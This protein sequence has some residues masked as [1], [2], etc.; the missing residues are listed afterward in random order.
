MPSFLALRNLKTANGYRDWV[1]VRRNLRIFVCSLTLCA[2]SHT[3]GKKG[4]GPLPMV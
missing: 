3:H 1:S 2:R 4:G